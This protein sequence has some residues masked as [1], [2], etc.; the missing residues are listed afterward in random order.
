MH[1]NN[2]STASQTITVVDNTAPIANC[3]NIDINL[4]AA[5]TATIVAGDINN[6]SSDA[7]GSVTL[8]ASKT[9]FDCTNLG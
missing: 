9:S 2:S 4:S 5:G 8:L 3:K 1:V 6:G 7:C